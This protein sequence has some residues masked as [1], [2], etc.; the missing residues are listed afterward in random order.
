VEEEVS[1]EDLD[2]SAEALGRRSA[3]VE[4]PGP[5]LEIHIR[6][7]GGSHGYLD[8]GGLGFMAR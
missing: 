3:G 6:T 1:V 8:G 5:G 7:A 2:T 4:D